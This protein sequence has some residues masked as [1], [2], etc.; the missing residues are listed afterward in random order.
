M[1]PTQMPCGPMPSCA[2]SLRSRNTGCPPSLTANGTRRNALRGRGAHSRSGS[3]SATSSIP[4]RLV[5]SNASVAP[6]SGRTAS[7]VR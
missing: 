6:S 4:S 2:A 3:I 1:A 5:M 7:T